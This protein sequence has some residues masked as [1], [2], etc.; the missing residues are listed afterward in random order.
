MLLSYA[1]NAVLSKA[2]AL[3]GKRIK[4]KNYNE[5][6]ALRNV[7]DIAVYLKRNTNYAD[8]LNGMSENS[9]HRTELERSIKSKLFVD[10]ESLG[11]YDLWVGEHFFDYI[12][13][14]AEIEQIMHSLTLLSAGQSGEYI[15]TVPVFFHTHAK[16]DLKALQHIKSYDDFL[17]IIKKSVYYKILLPFK[18]SPGERIN[19]TAIET[20]LYNYMYE[21]VFGVINKYVKGKAK[22]ELTDLFNTYIDLL[23]LIRIVR[24]KKFYNLDTE[25]MELAIIKRGTLKKEEL[26]KFINSQDNKKMMADMK[27]TKMGR[28]WF[29]RGLDIIDKVPT[30]M[31]FN[32]CKHNIRFSVYPPI[33][34]V[35]YIFLKETEILNLINIIEGVKYKLD[36]DE[37]KKMLIV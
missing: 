4:E 30:N 10:F 13:A 8:V 33:V 19:L 1:P 23:N 17:N 5:I 32:W 6:L 3:Y 35:S 31:R 27:E 29:S 2:R 22:K 24:M 16:F 26:E 18:P 36:P 14:R 20:A 11:R 28:K 12:M 21:V 7:S 9:V 25:Y 37:I 15:Q 34:L